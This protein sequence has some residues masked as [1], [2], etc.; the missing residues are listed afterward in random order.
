MLRV[1]KS[2]FD[3]LGVR[4]PDRRVSTAE[5]LEG[6]QNPVRLPLERLTGIRERRLAGEG[7]F[8]I[9]L[10]EQAV[11]DC[12]AHSPVRAADYDVLVCTNISRRDG[13]NEF[14]YEPAAALTLKKRLGFDKAFALDLTNACAGMWTGVYLVDALIRTGE[15]RHGM[16]VSGE[17]ISYLIETAQRE[18]TDFMDPQIASLTLGDAGVAVSMGLSPSPDVGLHDLDLY[19]LSKYSPYCVAKPTDKAHGGAV[20]YTD[21]IKVTEA[22]VPHAARH[23]KLVVDRNG[24]PL[25]RIDHIIPHQTSQLTMQEAKKEIQRLYQYDFGDCF[26]NNLAERGNTSSNSHFL[27]IA[28]A[29]QAGDVKPGENL[30]FC[31]SGSGQT[32]GTALYTMDQLPQRLSNGK[33]MSDTASATKGAVASS[34]PVLMAIDATA[35]A[36]PASGRCADTLAL[37]D[38]AAQACLQQSRFPKEEIDLLISCGTYRSEFVMEPAIAA[39]AGG[40]LLMNEDRSPADEHKTLAFDVISGPVGFLKSCYLAAELARAGQLEQAMLLASEVENNREVDPDNL[41]GIREMA[42][43]TVL[44][45]S[46]DGETG[47][48]AFCFRDFLD[49][50]ERERTV[51][52]WNAQG[53]AF[54]QSQRCPDRQQTFAA[55]IEQTVV[56]FFAEQG[57]EREEIA[58][59]LP[60]QISRAFVESL[61]QQLGFLR[62]QTVC[63]AEATDYA[64]SSVP[65]SYGYACEQGLAQPGDLG[66]IVSCGAGIQVGCALY[67]F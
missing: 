58:L 29:I 62:E 14:T 12:L 27:A 21:A 13:P 48:E 24:W 31:I 60:P 8:S 36:E 11:A 61:A 33:T 38:S 35:L 66:L 39:L 2:I 63:I 43:A 16:V 45:E 64:S 23:A 1:T 17:Y 4:L 55:C 54:L 6:C 49:Y 26:L 18:I 37:L 44:H 57:L 51:G 5:I 20:M 32:T 15:I 46:P 52:S 19:T 53:K 9:D 50:H 7:L 42:S 41:L 34:L 30:A 65:A 47:F 10:A 59:L 25:D 3:S 56:E 22:V 40:R 67:R 28:D